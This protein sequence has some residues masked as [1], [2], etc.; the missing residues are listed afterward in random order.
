MSPEWKIS[1]NLINGKRCLEH[2]HNAEDLQIHGKHGFIVQN[3]SG[4][5]KAGVTN[6]S[7]Y[8]QLAFTFGHDF[9]VQKGDEAWLHFDLSKFDLVYEALK[10]PK[11][12]RGQIQCTKKFNSAS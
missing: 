12:L 2:V 9:R 6:H 7:I 5:F 8:N 1:K 3:Q 4:T 11:Y 10:V